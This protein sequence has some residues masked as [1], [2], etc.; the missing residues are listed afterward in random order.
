MNEYA[1]S[2]RTMIE[3]QIRP[4]RVYDSR[5]IAALAEL[6]REAFVPRAM[7]GVAYVDEDVPLGYGRYLMEPMVL[8]KLMQAA[9]VSAADRAL[10]IGCGPGYSAALMARLA[11]RVVAVEEDA[12][13]ADQAKAAM[14]E[15]GILNVTVIRGPH[16]QG[17]APDAPYD[18]ILFDGAAGQIPRPAIGQLA[19][20]G[21]LVAVVAGAVMGAGKGTLVRRN[22]A[23]VSTRI[24]F[25][26]NTPPLPGLEKE[27]A[28][29]F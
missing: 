8:A 24:L 7:R 16:G 12:I 3:C 5:V 13:L 28:F 25:D 1:A 9:E 18:V 10:V 29:V 2:R 27:S 21:R 26:A 15:F 19:P 6:P 23:G 11:R 22:G 17:Y 4:N 14:T 20:N